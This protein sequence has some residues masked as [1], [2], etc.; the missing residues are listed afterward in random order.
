LPVSYWWEFMRATYSTTQAVAIRRQADVDRR[1]ASLAKLLQNLQNCAPAVTRD[2]W[3]GLPS[4]TPD[5]DDDDYWR[6]VA[7]RQW[8]ESFGG[9]VGDHLDRRVAAAD[10]DELKDAARDVKHYVDNH[11]A[12]TSAARPEV[13]ATLNDMHAAIDVIGRLFNKYTRLL[14]GESFAEITPV[15]THNWTAVFRVPWERQDDS[16]WRPHR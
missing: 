1:V 4:N 10:F 16:P 11:L 5:D 9:S 14:L 6:Q 13:T 2:W 3:L 12:H 7:R 8:D 15:I